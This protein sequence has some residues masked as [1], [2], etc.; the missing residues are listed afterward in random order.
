MRIRTYRATEPE[1]L[2]EGIFWELDGI[3][4]RFYAGFVNYS[5]SIRIVI[6]AW[7]TTGEVDGE[8]C[9][10]L[11]ATAD[12]IITGY[13]DPLS[14]LD[15][16]FMTA[17]GQEN[18]LEV[19]EDEDEAGDDDEVC[20]NVAFE[21]AE[22]NAAGRRAALLKRLKRVTKATW[23]LVHDA[24]EIDGWTEQGFRVVPPPSTI[25]ADEAVDVL[26]WGELPEDVY[27]LLRARGLEWD[28]ELHR[29][30]R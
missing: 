12:N 18:G 26:V 15:G 30:G 2:P 23:L 28:L 24:D 19:D 7:A 20:L 21:H 8:I 14:S 3:D 1:K 16:E 10:A 4:D 25:P 11:I 17:E 27:A 5:D 9:T 13:I 29:Y 22:P 6:V